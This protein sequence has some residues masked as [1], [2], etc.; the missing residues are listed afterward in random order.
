MK[1]LKLFCDICG[2]EFHPI[3]YGFLNGQVVRMNKDLQNQPLAFEGH[4]CGEHTNQLLAYID[5]LK[6]ANNN[7][8]G[9]GKQIDST[10]T[11]T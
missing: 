3:E 8:T 6:Y 4:Y 2:I 7:S 9:V 1:E 11:A 10:A 5:G